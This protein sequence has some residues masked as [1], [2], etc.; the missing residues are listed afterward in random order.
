MADATTS[1][2]IQDGGRNLIMKFTNVSDGTGQSAATLVDGSGLNAN[3]TTGAACSRI[4]L[5]RMWFSNV[6][7]GFKLFWNASTNMFIAQAPK[8]WTDTWDFTSSSED[9]SGIPNNAGSGINGDLLIT[10]ND[11]TDGDTYSVV[12]WALKHYSS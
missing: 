1:Q 4:V 8:D 6:G 9:L 12:I 2:T 11:H 5:Q 10:T 3:P 7:M